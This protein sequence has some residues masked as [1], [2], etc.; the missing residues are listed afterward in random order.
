M[1]KFLSS[2]L[3]LTGDTIVSLI[4][5]STCRCL[6]LF[7][8]S[9]LGV[10]NK[11]SFGHTQTL[12]LDLAAFTL[13]V[14]TSVK[15]FRFLIF[16]FILAEAIFHWVSYR[17]SF[18]KICFKRSFKLFCYSLVFGKPTDSLDGYAYYTLSF[19][20]IILQRNIEAE[21]CDILRIIPRLRFWKGYNFVCWKPVNTVQLYIFEFSLLS[22]NVRQN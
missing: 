11:F 4:T 9:F 20:R 1:H 6:F 2:S 18:Q 13:L 10:L 12:A 17:N 16:Y 15:P 3:R 7:L 14:E 21:I 22:L 8:F 5:W 19:I